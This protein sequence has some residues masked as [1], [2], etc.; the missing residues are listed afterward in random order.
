MSDTPPTDPLANPL[1]LDTGVDPNVL[2]RWAGRDVDPSRTYE[3]FVEGENV[4]ISDAVAGT[5]IIINTPGDG[6]VVWNETT[7]FN[8]G[9]ETVTVVAAPGIN[10]FVF[11]L[12]S[13]SEAQ[14]IMEITYQASG[15]E[16]INDTAILEQRITDAEMKVTPEAIVGTV[17]SS[18]Q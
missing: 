1:W 18:V 16:T 10:T 2:R 3:V 12:D 13:S 9:N 15:W 7:T 11:T 8:V 5:D 6:V 17:T 14:P 4:S